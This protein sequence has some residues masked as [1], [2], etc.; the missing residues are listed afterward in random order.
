MRPRPIDQ[1]PELG[2][3]GRLPVLVGEGAADPRL[4]GAVAASQLGQFR[5]R[6][7]IPA[8]V[9]GGFGQQLVVVAVLAGRHFNH[10]AYN[11]WNTK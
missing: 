4:D 11:V 8:R 2:P 5:A 7:P 6:R 1:H 9:G 10:C 3:V